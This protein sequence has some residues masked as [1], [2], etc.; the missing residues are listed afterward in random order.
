MLCLAIIV[1][2]VKLRKYES[3]ASFIARDLL[4]E[5]YYSTYVSL[6]TDFNLLDFKDVKRSSF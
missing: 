4:H 5:V 2:G 6:I 1:F 3:R